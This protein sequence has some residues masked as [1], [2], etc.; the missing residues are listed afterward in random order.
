MSVHRPSGLIARQFSI[1]FVASLQHTQLGV[2]SNFFSNLSASAQSDETCLSCLSSSRSLTRFWCSLSRL[3]RFL[4]ALNRQ[5]TQTMSFLT[6]LGWHQSR[7]QLDGH[8]TVLK[9][10]RK[11]NQ[12]KSSDTRPIGTIHGQFTIIEGVAKSSVCACRS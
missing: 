12:N 6:S 5:V 9:K 8:A 3:R 7:H 1:D 2:L 4:S 11:K 10:N